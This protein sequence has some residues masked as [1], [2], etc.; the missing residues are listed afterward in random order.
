[1]VGASVGFGEVRFGSLYCVDPTWSIGQIWEQS[2]SYEAVE[3]SEVFD[4]TKAIS[5]FVCPGKDLL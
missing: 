1:V 5:S 2:R 3:E 4:K